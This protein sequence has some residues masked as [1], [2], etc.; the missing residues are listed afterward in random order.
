MLN[1]QIGRLT[2]LLVLISLGL[3]TVT[4]QEP[5]YEEQLQSARN[6]LS[7]YR[8]WRDFTARN[9]MIWPQYRDRDRRIANVFNIRAF[10]TYLIIDHEGI[11]RFQSSGFG[12]AN[13]DAASGSTSRP[14]RRVRK[15]GS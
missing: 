3:V 12:G 5:T 1:T 8:V 11:L 14:R 2:T 9:Q 10:P 13:L 15:R 4:A 6:L 7:R